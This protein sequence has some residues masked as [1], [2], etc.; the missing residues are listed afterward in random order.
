MPA[1]VK[2]TKEEAQRRLSDVPVEYAFFCHDGRRL[3]N[4]AELQDALATMSDE[5]FAYHS[6]KDKSDFSNWVRDVI[7]DETL[8]RQLS[9]ASTLVQARKVVEQR[10]AFLSSKI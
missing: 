9:Q 5:V 10:I 3:Y 2:I 7:K 1:V 4:L 6:G 8:A